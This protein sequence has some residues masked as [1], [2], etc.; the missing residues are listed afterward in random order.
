MGSILTINSS[1]LIKLSLNRFTIFLKEISIA[2]DSVLSVNLI[3][4]FYSFSGSWLIFQFS[5]L[6]DTKIRLTKIQLYIR[7][8][9]FRN[10]YSCRKHAGKQLR[11]QL[12][13]NLYLMIPTLNLK[14]CLD[15]QNKC[16]MM[17]VVDPSKIQII[18]RSFYT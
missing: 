7:R 17:S 4:V 15:C 10:T 18:I 5:T 11:E 16:R 12:L 14:L 9:C 2:C 8:S 1:N 3:F 6:Q 13:G